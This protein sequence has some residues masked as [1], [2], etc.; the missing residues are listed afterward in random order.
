MEYQFKKLDERL[1]FYMKAYKEVENELKSSEV[2]R[3]AVEKEIENEI[4]GTL[5]DT[6]PEVID[7]EQISKLEDTYQMNFDD[8]ITEHEKLREANIAE[9]ESLKSDDRYKESLNLVINDDLKLVAKMEEDEVFSYLIDENYG[10]DDFNNDPFIFFLGFKFQPR[11]WKF[12]KIADKKAKEFGMASFEE[13]RKLWEGLRINYKSLEDNKKLSA[14]LEECNMIEEKIKYLEKAIQDYLITRRKG[15][16]DAIVQRVKMVDTK[17]V[18]ARFSNIMPLLAKYRS[19]GEEVYKLQDNKSVIMDNINAV[20]KMTGL[21]KQG[22]LQLSRTSKELFFSNQNPTTPILEIITDAEWQAITQ[23]LAEKGIKTSSKSNY[24][25]YS[26]TISQDEK[27]AI[28]KKHQ[29]K[30]GEIFIDPK[31]VGKK[32]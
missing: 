5:N 20:E 8:V 3:E 10:T 26:K 6:I 17:V 27:A 31:L 23:A 14:V 28:L 19:L 21:A 11:Y 2:E 32:K 29:V 25:V 16:M 9:L 22:K 12:K 18:E 4:I 7:S 13:M 24:K 15:I 1:D 30:E